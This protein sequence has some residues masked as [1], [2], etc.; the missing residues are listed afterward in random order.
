MNLADE[1]EVDILGVDPA[2]TAA[3]AAAVVLPVVFGKRRKDEQ[4]AAAEG[5]K[6]TAKQPLNTGLTLSAIL[7]PPPPSMVRPKRANQWGPAPPGKVLPPATVPGKRKFANQWTKPGSKPKAQNQYTKGKAAKGKQPNQVGLGGL[8]PT[9]CRPR[10]PCP[11]PPHTL[12][13][14]PKP[15]PTTLAHPSPTARARPPP[16]TPSTPS[17]QPPAPTPNGPN[18]PHQLPPLNPHPLA[19]VTRGQLASLAP[20]TRTRTCHRGLG[21]RSMPKRRSGPGSPL[22]KPNPSSPTNTPPNGR[23]RRR[24][25]AGSGRGGEVVLRGFARSAAGGEGGVVAGRV[26]RR[27]DRAPRTTTVTPTRAR[28]GSFAPDRS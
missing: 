6:R 23:E 1:Y 7:P 16:Q 24:R 15:S 5:R 14:S 27:L 13:P 28:C 22:R 17:P 3:E 4:A 2:E 26:S 18:H 12:A 10:P 20:R 9:P 21:N 19:R 8:V 25:G 11:F